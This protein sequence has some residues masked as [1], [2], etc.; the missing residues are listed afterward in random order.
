MHIKIYVS[1]KYQKRWD[2]WRQEPISLHICMFRGGQNNPRRKSKIEKPETETELAKIMS[3]RFLLQSQF[4]KDRPFHMSTRF[5]AYMSTHLGLLCLYPHLIFYPAGVQATAGH[6]QAA[7]AAVWH[8]RRHRGSQFTAHSVQRVGVLNKAWRRIGSSQPRR[9]LTPWDHH[10]DALPAH[11]L[12][13]FPFAPF[14]MDVR[15]H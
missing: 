7:N 12:T 4:S 15:G 10:L 1:V 3:T 13:A 2:L 11:A 5:T 9:S 6:Q 8:R 14:A